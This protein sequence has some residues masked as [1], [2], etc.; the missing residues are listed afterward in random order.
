MKTKITPNEIWKEYN[1]GIDY[2]SQLDLYDDVEYNQNFYNGN[3]WEGVNAPDIEKPVINICRQAVDYFVSMLVSDDIGV[4]CSIPDGVDELTKQAV[5]YITTQDIENVFEQTKFKQK[6]RQFIKD[7][8][9]N[10]D[11]FFH[12]WYNTDKNRDSKYIGC[13]DLEIIDSVNVVFGDP[14][15]FSVEPQ[16]YILVVSKLPLDKVRDMVSEEDQ[17]L[18]VPDGQDLNTINYDAHSEDNYAT[19]ITKLWKEG[20]TVWYTKTTQKAVITPPVNLKQKMYPIVKQSWKHRKNSYHGISP[21]TEIRQ[22]QIMINKYYM[23]LN[24]FIKKLSFP[25]LLYDMTKIPKWTNK[26]ESIGVNGDPRDA[27]AMTSPTVQLSEQVIG[28]IENLIDKTKSTLGIYDVALGNVQPENTSAIIALQKT[29][30]QPL[31]LQRLDYLQ[32][33]EDSVRIIVDIM[34]AFYGFREVPFKTEDGNGIMPFNYSD[35]SFEEFGMTI[36]VGSAYY[37]SEVTQIQTLDNMYK[38]GIIPDPITYLEQL[39]NGVVK[40]RGE[41]IDA[42]RMKQQM[43]MQMMMQSQLMQQTPSPNGTPSVPTNT[44]DGLPVNSLKNVR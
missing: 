33:V 28:F 41:I 20:G 15:E 44:V 14:A 26:I 36:E 22:N 30:S 8:A 16:P 34:S 10:G 6:T 27:I 21:L 29:A 25:K 13:I 1:A 42:I 24:E 43:D 17:Y 35:I 37:W 23:M 39:P 5:E 31:E 40:N 4:T 19:V 9:I 2:K 32:V 11:A 7:C 3:Q 38:N 12:W 18:I